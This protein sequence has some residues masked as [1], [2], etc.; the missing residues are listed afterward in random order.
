MAE[1]KPVTVLEPGYAITREQ[2]KSL[3]TQNGDMYSLGYINY[4]S[5]SQLPCAVKI[6]NLKKEEDRISAQREREVLIRVNHQNIAKTYKIIEKDNQMY[7]FR[8]YDEQITLKIMFQRLLRTSQAFDEMNMLNLGSQLIHCLNYMESLSLTNRDLNPSNILFSSDNIY[9]IFDFGSSRI[10][11]ENQLLQSMTIGGNE[12]FMSPQ[13]LG[14]DQ[15]TEIDYYK[16]DIWSLGMILYYFGE[17]QYPWKKEFREQDPEF[18]AEIEKMSDPKYKLPFQKIKSEQMR[19]LIRRMLDYNQERRASAKE[20][21]ED[22]L[23]KDQLKILYPQEAK[24]EFI[25]E[26]ILKQ[27]EMKVKQPLDETLEELI[28]NLQIRY[29]TENKQCINQGSQVYK[30]YHSLLDYQMFNKKQLWQNFKIRHYTKYFIQNFVNEYKR[31]SELSTRQQ[32]EL[33]LL[34]QTIDSSKAFPND[35][36]QLIELVEKQYLAD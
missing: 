30:S 14:V 3:R 19:N 2:I 35:P 12:F 6:N 25:T 15:S 26:L 5:E 29:F 13:M 21:L 9:K 20:L 32:Q 28:F 27:S 17:S 4:G 36:Q 7:I 8:E 10:I 22:R 31:Q 33:L 16:S 34:L 11:D 18:D 23:I 24:L 1:L